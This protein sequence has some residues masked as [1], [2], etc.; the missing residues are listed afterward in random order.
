MWLWNLLMVWP[1]TIVFFRENMLSLNNRYSMGGSSL[2]LSY[3]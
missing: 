1:M 2:L 3:R